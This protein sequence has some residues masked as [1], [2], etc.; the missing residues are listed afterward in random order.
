MSQ[1]KI[2]FHGQKCINSVSYICTKTIV[3]TCFMNKT[4]IYKYYTYL[5]PCVCLN[6]WERNNKTHKLCI[7]RCILSCIDNMDGKQHTCKIHYMH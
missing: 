2:E 6:A 1:K 4:A 5:R 7:V 3:Y